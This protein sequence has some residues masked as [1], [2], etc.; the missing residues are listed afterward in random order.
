MPAPALLCGSK[1]KGEG[2]GRRKEKEERGTKVERKRI[3]T[4]GGAIS[5]QTFGERALHLRVVMI[6]H[7]RV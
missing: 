6:A 5:A 7:T 4:I 2:A 3:E 1:R